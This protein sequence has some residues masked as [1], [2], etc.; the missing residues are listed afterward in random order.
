MPPTA[1][2]AVLA[3]ADS[4]RATLS[5]ARALAEAGRQID[6]AGLDG[7]VATLCAA[8]LALPPACGAEARHAL[9]AL[10]AELESLLAL[11]PRPQTG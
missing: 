3:T 9:H 11:L 10:R 1:L 6:M 4:L 2:Q 7:E 8:A 5:L